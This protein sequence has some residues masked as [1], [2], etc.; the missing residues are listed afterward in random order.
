MAGAAGAHLLV[1]GVGR[2]TAG[3][4]DRRHPDAVAHLPEL[5]LGAPEAAQAEDCRLEPVGV[6]TFERT[7]VEEVRLGRRD[8]VGAA[9]ERAVGRRHLELLAG[10]EHGER[11]VALRRMLLI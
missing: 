9:L 2:G 4:T 6:G 1:G 3:I 5:A 10:K 11:P 8:R 7:L